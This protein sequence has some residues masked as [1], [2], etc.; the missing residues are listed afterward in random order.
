MGVMQIGRTRLRRA[1]DGLRS[2]S[3]IYSAY[4]LCSCLLQDSTHRHGPDLVV[5]SVMLGRR[6]KA[7]LAGHLLLGEKGGWLPSSAA[8]PGARAQSGSRGG[9][10]V[11][12]RPQPPEEEVV[13]YRTREV[14]GKA[15]PRENRGHLPEIAPNLM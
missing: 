12:A 1:F 4:Q 15:S 10:Y 14:P 9:Q 5:N 7:G 11:P 13:A 6:S 3:S 8:G 2:R